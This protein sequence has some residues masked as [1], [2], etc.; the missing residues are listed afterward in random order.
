MT[1]ILSTS[2]IVDN[3]LATLYRCVLIN[4]THLGRWFPQLSETSTKCVCLKFSSIRV[5]LN[6]QGN[7][8]T[9]FYYLLKQINMINTRN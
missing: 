4:N 7:V 6:R 2:V 8:F 1:S 5:K 9:L 3:V